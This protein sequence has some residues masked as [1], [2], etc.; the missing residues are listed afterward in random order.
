MNEYETVCILQPDL[1]EAKL[2]RVKERVSKILEDNKAQLL[3]TKDWGKR[4]LAYIIGKTQFGHYFFFNYT[5]TGSFIAEL[6]RMLK[7]EEGIIRYMTVKIAERTEHPN[8]KPPKKVSV[9]EEA[10][11]N[12][13]DSYDDSRGGYGDRG[14]DRGGGGGGYR[15]SEPRELADKGGDNA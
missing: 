1:P 10:K 4:K 15:R 11:L 12:F 2:T 7:Y 13:E 8:A 3:E 6:E 9:L 5:G 14:Y